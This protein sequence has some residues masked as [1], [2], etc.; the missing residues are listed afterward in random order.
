MGW[1]YFCPGGESGPVANGQSRLRLW[2]RL[3]K[4][5]QSQLGEIA[6]QYL[7]DKPMEMVL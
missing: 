5:Y 3:R 4:A 6:I 1:F 7:T 2:N